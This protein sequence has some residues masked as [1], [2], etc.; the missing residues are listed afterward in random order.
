MRCV[1]QRLAAFCCMYK[2]RRSEDGQINS[3]NVYVWISLSHGKFS[4]VSTTECLHET[5]QFSIHIFLL[6][7]LHFS[8]PAR[9]T[10]VCMWPFSASNNVVTSENPSTIPYLISNS[11]V[12]SFDPCASFA[13]NLFFS[14]LFER[15]RQHTW[16]L[17]YSENQLCRFLFTFLRLFAYLFTSMCR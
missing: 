6:L 13:T 16:I 8:S 12:R 5:R 15:I 17:V 2:S 10:L 9:L 4:I 1:T 14:P 11:N 7:Y 3:Q